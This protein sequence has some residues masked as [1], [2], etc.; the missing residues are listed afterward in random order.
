ML[1]ALFTRRLENEVRLD[2]EEAEGHAVLLALGEEQA[3][4]IA[5]V[6]HNAQQGQCAVG[7]Q[8]IG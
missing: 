4:G 2:D 7:V 3:V 5:T 1:A 8:Y 6:A